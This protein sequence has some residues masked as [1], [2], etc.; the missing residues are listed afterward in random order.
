MVYSSINLSSWHFHLKQKHWQEF[1]DRLA[2]SK[3]ECSCM[4]PCLQN[5]WGSTSFFFSEDKLFLQNMGLSG[6][7][8]SWPGWTPFW[9]EEFNLFSRVPSLLGLAATL[10][11]N[12]W[13]FVMQLLIQT[14]PDRGREK[15]W[16][17]ST[18]LSRKKKL[19]NVRNLQIIGI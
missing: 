6:I 12:S 15:P 8:S 4:P 18:R 19:W 3:R 17:C 2:G 7:S 14:E 5:R 11:T 13:H 16:I 10:G 1:N 9:V